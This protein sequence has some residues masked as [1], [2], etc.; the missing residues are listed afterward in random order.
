MDI[1]ANDAVNER[2]RE[3]A[4][5][6]REITDVPEGSPCFL[7]QTTSSRECIWDEIGDDI[8]ARGLEARIW[9]ERSEG[10]FTQ[11]VPI[12]AADRAARYACYHHYIFTVSMWIRD[13]GCVC[14]PTCVETNIRQRFPGD[15]VFVGFNQ[16]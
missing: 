7:C 8:L 16:E 5:M 9:F 13:D 11:P 14:I 2:T 15:G 3:I 1:I 10:N 4:H 6:V 12:A